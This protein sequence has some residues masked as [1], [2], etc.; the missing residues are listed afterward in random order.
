M[1]VFKNHS[2]YI[3]FFAFITIIVF[4][5]FI[6]FNVNT[7][8][9]YTDV[10]PTSG[11]YLEYNNYYLPLDTHTYAIYINDSF[12]F[13]ATWDQPFLYSYGDLAGYS[14]PDMYLYGNRTQ[15]SLQDATKVYA[16]SINSLPVEVQPLYA[17]L[18]E[19][20]IYHAAISYDNT[21]R[22]YI[23]IAGSVNNGI[24]LDMSDTGDDALEFDISIS[25]KRP[26]VQYMNSVKDAL[27]DIAIGKPSS[28][29]TPDSI[30]NWLFDYDGH[31]IVQSYKN[32]SLS[33]F[34]KQ[35]AITPS[36]NGS[37]TL[38]FSSSGTLQDG[39]VVISPSV[40]E[41][42]EYNRKAGGIYKP[43]TDEEPY[44]FGC[45]I[46]ET[47]AVT[48]KSGSRIGKTTYSRFDVDGNLTT[49]YS[50][51]GLL[52]EVTSETIN[53]SYVEASQ[54]QIE[55]LQK[56]IDDLKVQ[57]NDNMKEYISNQL[58]VP[59]DDTG[60][61]GG[62]SDIISTIGGLTA[63][64][65]GVSAMFALF[66][67]CLPSFVLHIISFTITSLCIISIYKALRG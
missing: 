12:Q 37:Y 55:S 17:P 18:S 14:E 29:I 41:W 30:K 67:S 59:T 61:L 4:S 38:S 60:I 54:T 45:S 35:N 43:T 66:F 40:E 48:P 62:F 16:T 2:K 22:Q 39:Y 51:N 65:G 15:S 1:D 28:S 23:A 47:I 24:L 5:F 10:K 33:I 56:Q 8:Y 26:S 9:A 27:S 34:A 52:S 11:A 32:N 44:Y 36:Y 63:T 53:D 19:C 21:I 64:V 3:Y 25:G 13:G 6:I 57:Y 49:Y 58:N 20:P 31:L 50:I 7:A 42:L 46:I